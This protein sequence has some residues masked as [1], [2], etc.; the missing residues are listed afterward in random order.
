M[1]YEYD[2]QRAPRGVGSDTA[3]ASMAKLVT[4][5]FLRPDRET[6]R[7]RLEALV[8]Q[9]DNLADEVENLASKF[10][11]TAARNQYIDRLLSEVFGWDVRNERGVAAHNHE[12][13]VERTI[14][15]SDTADTLGRPDYTLR[16]SR[17]DRLVVEAKRPSLN[18]KH[19]AGA[20]RQ[21]RSYGFSLAL[22]ATVLTNFSVISFYDSTIQPSPTDDASFA[23]LPGLC[24][25]YTE[26]LDRFDDLWERLAYDN[27]ASDRFYEVFDFADHPRGTSP[28]DRAFLAQFNNWRL[29]LARDVARLRPE[30]GAAEVGRRVQ[31]LLNALLFLR[32][33]ED[34][35]IHEYRDLLR[36]AEGAVDTGPGSRLMDRLT[37]ADRL[38][39]AGLFSALE[40]V[41][42]PSGEVL[43][44]I[45][46]MYWP[47]SPYAFG[48]VTPEVL[49]GIYEQ[50]LGDRIVLAESGDVLLEEKPEVTHSNG[51]VPTPDYIV[52][53]LVDRGLTTKLVGK[54]VADISTLTVLD[55]A[56]GSGAFLVAA[57]QRL[58]RF[59]EGELDQLT[60]SQKSDIV[61]RHL[62]GVDIDGEAVEVARLSLLLTILDDESLNPAVDRDVLPDLSANLQCGNSV[63]DSRFDANFDTPASDPVRRAVVNPF[64]WKHSFPN[65]MSPVGRGFDA[66]IG[67]PP[68]IRI[69]EV[70]EHYSDQL[71]FLQSAI[72]G[73]VSTSMSFD[74][75]MPF[76]ERALDLVATDGKVALIVPQRFAT[77]LAAGPLRNKLRARIDSVV[78]FGTQQ[79]FPGRSTYTA[80]IEVGSGSS[81]E[82]AVELVDDLYLW[83][84]GHGGELVSWTR[85]ELTASPWSFAND[86]QSAVFDKLVATCEQRLSDVAE[87]FVGVQSSADDTLMVKP[88]HV[89]GD[90]IYFQDNDGDQWSIESA[91]TRPALVDARLT[92]YG[93]DPK[94]D[95]YA[96]FPYEI[97]EGRSKKVA[98]LIQPKSLRSRFPMAWR[99]LSAQRDKLSSRNISPDRGEAF[100]AYG[101]SQNIARMDDPKIIVR[102]LS[103]IPQY[104]WDPDGRIVS[105]GGNGPYTV[106]RALDASDVSN[107]VLIALLSHP[108]IDAMLPSLGASV[109]RGGYVQHARSS[110]KS[111][112]IPQVSRSEAMDIES[113]VG[114][115]HDAVRN[116]REETDSAIRASLLARKEWIRSRIEQIVSGMLGL[117]SGDL[118]AFD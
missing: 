94:H 61:K 26:Y 85:S 89:D 50:S 102:T 88:T 12:V 49:A 14:E 72:S 5:T 98:K 106:V 53:A 4:M 108:V 111:L 31:R 29:G 110:L 57:A 58:F 30:L 86:K 33:C 105:G 117:D 63:I 6:A 48:V 17:Q 112:P 69:Q 118:A 59:Y 38:F 78:Y 3:N 23:R 24:I 39:N 37:S 27:L 18:I 100:Y 103:L 7:Q 40:A 25:P 109:H 97:G 82:V 8:E 46:E 66:I 90:Y 96:I 60:L 77:L 83:R 43:R 56:H 107:W 52:E 42:P 116:L 114:Q 73:Y 1:P 81:D 10:S 2:T 75:Y 9:Y 67:N 54:S 70:A 91:I 104:V 113:L 34:R 101:R 22:P 20:A 74:M 79:V 71:L 16:A 80:L 15:T 95:R 35:R 68:Y 55:M 64:E 47:E 99:Y 36:A 44:V 19:D 51:I 115:M 13:V 32:I 87:I 84:N 92:E 65:I 62:Y 41:D 21:A 76:I 28:F 11:E 45:R 93:V